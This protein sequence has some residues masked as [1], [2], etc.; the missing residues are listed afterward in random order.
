MYL[1]PEQ[2]DFLI[3]PTGRLSKQAKICKYHE[4]LNTRTNYYL[5][6]GV[7]FLFPFKVI[8]KMMLEY[9]SYGL[10]KRKGNIAWSP[11]GCKRET[12]KKKY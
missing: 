9:I 4:E 10:T 5:R 1:Y 7:V 12:G 6:V 3:T 11:Y 8:K 2:I